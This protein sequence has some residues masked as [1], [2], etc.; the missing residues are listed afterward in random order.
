MAKNSAKARIFLFHGN[1]AIMSR[2]SL[3]RW[4]RAFIEKHDDVSHHRISFYTGSLEVL[5]QAMEQIITEQSLFVNPALYV[6]YRPTAQE[7]GKRGVYS[8]ILLKVASQLLK[9]GRDDITLLIWEE[10]N[11]ATDHI[12]TKWFQEHDLQGTAKQYEFTVPQHAELLHEAATYI[13][14]EGYTLDTA[15]IR[16]L[17]SYLTQ[18]DKEQR[19]VAR[20]RSGDILAIDMRR[21]W[22][23]NVLDSALL[24]AQ[25]K[26]ITVQDIEHCTDPIQADAT[27]FEVA[28][29]VEKQQWQRVRFLMS[30]W[31]EENDM[32][33]YFVLLGVLRQRYRTHLPHSSAQYALDLLAEMEVLT[34]NGMSKMAWLFDVF[35]F[36]MEEAQQTEP[37]LD[38]RMV[39]LSVQ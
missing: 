37:L 9:Q 10:K 30:T 23:W 26:V 19:S 11:L 32:G 20:L 27:P 28:N 1:D 13:E 34:K 21:S 24:A 39:W 7:K 16:L 25:G 22:L 2:R 14:A 15:A 36:R 5:Q 33:P 31:N 12:M 17:Q 3:Q 35:T 18:M 29:A 8:E 4:E 38:P 6:I